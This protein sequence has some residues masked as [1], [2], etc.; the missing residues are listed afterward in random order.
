MTYMPFFQKIITSWIFFSVGEKKSHPLTWYPI[1][2]SKTTDLSERS[3]VDDH[4]LLNI[5]NSHFL[6]S[7]TYGNNKTAL[8]V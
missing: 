6:K 3:S 5:L 1:S 2:F 8:I 7:L 4:P